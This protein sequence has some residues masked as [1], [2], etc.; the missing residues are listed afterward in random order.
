MNVDPATFAALPVHV[1]ADGSTVTAAV[2]CTLPSKL[3]G[4]GIGRPAASWD[5]DLQL[6]SADPR[7]CCWEI[8]SR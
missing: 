6:T 8:S 4:N 3:A 5:L 2:R 1:S 7:H